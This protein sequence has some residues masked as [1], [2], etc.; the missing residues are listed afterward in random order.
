[1]QAWQQ[2]MVQQLQQMQQRRQQQAQQP[3]PVWQQA[4]GQLQRGG[5]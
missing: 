5:R 2:Q 4:P 3:V 1:M